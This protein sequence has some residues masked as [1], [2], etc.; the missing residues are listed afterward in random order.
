MTRKTFLTASLAGLYQAKAE[1]FIVAPYL[2]IGR[3]AAVGAQTEMEVLWHG[4]D[5]SE[6]WAVQYRGSGEMLWRKAEPPDHRPIRLFSEGNDVLRVESWSNG[7]DDYGKPARTSSYSTVRLPTIEPHRVWKARLTGLAPGSRFDYQVMLNGKTVFQAEGRTRPGKGQRARIAFVSDFGDPIPPPRAIAHRIF[8]QQPDVVV[9]PGDIVYL[10][11]RVSEYRLCHFPNYNNDLAG[12][13]TGAPL[14]RSIPTMAGLGEHDTGTNVGNPAPHDIL[15]YYFYWSQPLNGPSLKIGDSSV[16]PI[17]PEDARQKALLESAGQ[18]FPVMAHFSAD[19]GDVHFTFLD[20][21]RHV[22][23]NNPA[24]RGWLQEDLARVPEDMWKVVICYLP[25]F[26]SGKDYQ[27]QKMRIISEIVQQQNV[28]LMIGGMH[29]SFQRSKPV[30]YR[31]YSRTLGAVKDYDIVLPGEFTIDSAYDGRKNLTPKGIIHVVT[32]SG[33]HEM[34][35]GEQTQ[36]PATWQPFT[37]TYIADRYSFSL[38]DATRSQLEF[39]QLDESGA[40]LDAFLL[41]RG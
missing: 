32:G 30:L 26:H 13:A 4:R 34:H 2:Q 20:T 22:D 19:V 24:L 37:Q 23:W 36:N 8:L 21:A 17:K 41:K 9:M 11:G 12:H 10:H 25:L 39:R 31:P 7:N 29:H 3:Q 28:S 1:P 35:N 14:L 6:S 16:F 33:G 15:G 38:I 27:R 18:N 40:E 5:D